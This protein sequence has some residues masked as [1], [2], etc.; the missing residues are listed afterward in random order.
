MTLTFP[1]N[2]ALDI[3]RNRI[4]QLDIQDERLDKKAQDN[5]QIVSIIFAI[6]GAI[7]LQ[8]AQPNAINPTLLTIVF[9][10]YVIIVGL[11]YYVLLPKKW[12]SP[13]PT[14]PVAMDR[15]VRIPDTVYYRRLLK[16]YTEAIQHNE[17]VIQLK[18]RVVL[19]ATTLAFIDFILIIVALNF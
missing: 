13:L 2:N 7:K 4:A 6:V 19:A 11:S 3:F 16:T 12:L 15:V 18:G 1:Q 8:A 14:S 9:I 5:I 10:I 17:S